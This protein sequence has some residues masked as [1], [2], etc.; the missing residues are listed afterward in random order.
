MR[1][2][3]PKEC[4]RELDYHALLD[5]IRM[6][7][8]DDVHLSIAGL[9]PRVGGE[10]SRI[11]IAGTLRAIGYSWAAGFAIGEGGRLL[12]YEPDFVSASLE[13]FDG[14]DYF[15]ITA[16]FGDVT[17]LIDDEGRAGDEFSM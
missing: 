8:G 17:F 7:E 1:D 12:L 6:L 4:E 13:T 14:N 5:T 15:S 11:G 3:L 9:A 10:A 16:R 2:E